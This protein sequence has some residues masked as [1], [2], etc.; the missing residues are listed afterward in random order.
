MAYNAVTGVITAPVS[1]R[2]IQKCFVV[3]LSK[4]ASGVTTRKQSA[5]LGTIIAA[6]VGDT[7]D[8]WTVVSRIYMNMWAKF[9]PVIKA[10]IV[11]AL[12]DAERASVNYGITNIPTWSNINNMATFWLLENHASSA[13]Y[14]DCGLKDEYWAYE[15]PGGTIQQP[16]RITDYAK[17]T[18]LG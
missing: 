10:S 9:K 4:T 14:P 13:S 1:I 6:Q 16:L 2:D 8:G 17:S 3:V 18:T 15:I 12:T 11:M 7:V 5:D